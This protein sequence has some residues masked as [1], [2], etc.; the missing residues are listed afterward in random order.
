MD[1]EEPIY[2]FM[3]A[4]EDTSRQ[5]DAMVKRLP[6]DIAAIL[7]QQWQQS[8]WRT[9]LPAAATRTAEAAR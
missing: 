4:A 2:D 5:L 6:G 9:E 8:P 7:Q 1:S 3:A